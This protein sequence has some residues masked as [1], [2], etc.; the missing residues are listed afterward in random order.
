MRHDEFPAAENPYGGF[1]AAFHGQELIR[2]QRQSVRHFNG[3]VFVEIVDGLRIDFRFRSAGIEF[4]EFYGLALEI[5]NR[6]AESV[7]A[8]TQIQVFGDQG[9]AVFSFRA[10][11]EHVCDLKNAVVRDAHIHFFRHFAF[12]RQDH[13]FAGRLAACR[14]MQG[15]PF[16]KPAFAAEFVDH[17]YDLS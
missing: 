5:L 8:E 9:D 3:L 15:N 7:R 14:I 1:R 12:A 16:R 4:V 13:E 10:F 11:Q 6:N 2:M 17:S